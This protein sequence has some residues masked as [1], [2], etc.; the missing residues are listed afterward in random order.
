MRDLAFCPTCQ[1]AMF[2]CKRRSYTVENNPTDP[3]DPDFFPFG[4]CHGDCV[5]LYCNSYNCPQKDLAEHDPA[6]GLL[7]AFR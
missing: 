6:C 3:D 7:G 5:I 2:A 1:S 4:A